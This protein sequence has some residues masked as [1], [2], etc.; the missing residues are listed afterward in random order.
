VWGLLA[1]FLAVWLSLQ[2]PLYGQFNPLAAFL[3]TLQPERPQ[4]VASDGV[5]LAV[6]RTAGVA[7]RLA[8][9][10]ARQ[11][12]SLCTVFGCFGVAEITCGAI[13]AFR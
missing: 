11:S 12:S 13:C 8:R 2:L 9:N 3:A 7:L 10:R 5:R 1:S 4:N 6:Y